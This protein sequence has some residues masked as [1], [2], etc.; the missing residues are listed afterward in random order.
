MSSMTRK[1]LL[2]IRVTGLTALVAISVGWWI[3]R[4]QTETGKETWKAEWQRP[5]A[6]IP[7][8]SQPTRTVDAHG[9]PEISDPPSDDDIATSRAFASAL[10]PVE[11]EE[12][13]T[14]GREQQNSALGPFLRTHRTLARD[15]AWDH[16]RK[17][18]E[19]NVPARWKSALQLEVATGLFARGFFVD[20]WETAK[21]VWDGLNKRRELNSLRP[22]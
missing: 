7:G 13:Q 12:P 3:F 22:Q 20:S 4:T 2:F 19:G 1:K 11:T 8:Q 15:E 18:V 9:M 5:V 6:T 10:L 21:S 17:Y 16:L 14:G